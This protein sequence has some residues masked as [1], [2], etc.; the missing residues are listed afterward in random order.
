VNGL[1]VAYPGFNQFRQKF[2]FQ[3]VSMA[4]LF[5]SPSAKTRA[6]EPLY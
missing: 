4:K 3:I 1:C 5:I 2:S 6:R